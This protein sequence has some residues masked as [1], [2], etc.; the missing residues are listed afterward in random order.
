MRRTFIL[1]LAL[2]LLSFAICP[3]SAQMESQLALRRYTTQDGLPQM[4][5]ERLWQ[6]SRGYIYVGTLSGFVRFDGHSFTP[7]LKGRRMNIVGFAEVEHEV[8]A[9]GFFRQWT[10]GYND[11]KA[12]PLDPQGHWLLN[13]LNA[14][15]LPNGYVLVEDSL[16]EHRRLCRLTRM[17][18]EQ[19][20]SN[21]LLDRYQ[22]VASAWGR[23]I[24]GSRN[25]ILA[26][27]PEHRMLD[28]LTDDILHPWCAV[29]GADRRLWVGSSSGLFTMAEDGI[30]V[31]MDYAQKLIVSIIDADRQGLSSLPR[32]IPYFS[33]AA[34]R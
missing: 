29:Q 6:D 16:E 34:A 31:K 27:D 11:L 3:L 23:L 24:I 8:R 14:G 13:N 25:A 4:Q 30:S 21:P 12:Q 22:F 15:S 32:Q 7:F 5:T 17:G 18:L 2:C 33:C 1:A 20:L 26:Y 9:L 28:T 10:V 19:V